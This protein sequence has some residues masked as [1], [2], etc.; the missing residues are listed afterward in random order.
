M[1]E[2]TEKPDI[3]VQATKGDGLGCHA[4]RDKMREAAEQGGRVQVPTLETGSV[5]FK[6]AIEVRQAT[7]DSPAFAS[8]T[9]LM[10]T[11]V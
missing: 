1:T 6:V 11:S 10:K 5:A 8:S 2:R 7:N 4:G 9:I 3:D